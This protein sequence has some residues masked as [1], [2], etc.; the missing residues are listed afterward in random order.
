[1][2]KDEPTALVSSPYVGVRDDAHIAVAPQTGSVVG[3]CIEITVYDTTGD[4]Q[5]V[6][7]IYATPNAARTLH[8][9]LGEVLAVTG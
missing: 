5:S 7:T 4:W 3:D 6:V 2:K 1:M 9:K 8:A